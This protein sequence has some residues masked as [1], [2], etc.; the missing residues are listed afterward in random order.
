MTGGP[1]GYWFGL[2]LRSCV[3]IAGK[4]SNLQVGNSAIA[5]LRP[6][7]N[8]IYREAGWVWVR[9]GDV[10]SLL[11]ELAL[12]FVSE[13]ELGPQSFCANLLLLSSL[14]AS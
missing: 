8:V 2:V 13:I 11:A 6:W 12:A 7:N 1:L 3:D 9:Q 10:N 5:T 4:V 14:F